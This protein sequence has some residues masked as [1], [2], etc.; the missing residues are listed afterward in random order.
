M[1]SVAY[2]SV[3]PEQ[4]ESL[5]LFHFLAGIGCWYKHKQHGQSINTKHKIPCAVCRVL[6]KSV[7]YLPFVWETQTHSCFWNVWK[8][9]WRRVR[10]V[11]TSFIIMRDKTMSDTLAQYPVGSSEGRKNKAASQQCN[12]SHNP[13]N[14][15][16]SHL[17]PCDFYL[18]PKLKR[19]IWLLWEL[20][21]KF[22][23][24]MQFCSS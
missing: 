10:G 13:E 19:I 21:R 17:A 24:N 9:V 8:Y 1:I 18:F 11:R 2:L 5:L 4:W 23:L 7:S 20:I 22:L 14:P 16:L 15:C 3:G 6:M 12:C